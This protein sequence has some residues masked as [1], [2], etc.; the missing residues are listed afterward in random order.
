MGDNSREE[1]IQLA[2]TVEQA[3][4]GIGVTPV[5]LCAGG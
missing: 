1:R 2:L 3:S 4:L 5:M